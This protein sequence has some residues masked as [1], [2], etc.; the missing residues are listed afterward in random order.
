MR[1]KDCL[2][3][4]YAMANAENGVLIH[5][6]RDLFL[7]YRALLENVGDDKARQDGIYIRVG[8]AFMGLFS[9]YEDKKTLINNPAEVINANNLK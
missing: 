3:L 1:E 9:A 2:T 7:Q 8:E 5:K 4:A 6:M